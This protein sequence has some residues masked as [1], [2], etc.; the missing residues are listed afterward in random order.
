[1]VGMSYLSVYTHVVHYF[2][3]LNQLKNNG[4]C[5]SYYNSAIKVPDTEKVD[6]PPEGFT[7]LLKYGKRKWLLKYRE[8][9]AHELDY[10]LWFC[11]A[12]FSKTAHFRKKRH[13]TSSCCIDHVYL[14]QHKRARIHK[15]NRHHKFMDQHEHGKCPVA[16]T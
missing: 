10:G 4:V 1:M 15:N 12:L 13:F 7:N 6:S 9:E 8:I 2:K 3:C 14:S 5:V 11:C 16:E